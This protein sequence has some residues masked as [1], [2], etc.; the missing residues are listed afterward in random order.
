VLRGQQVLFGAVASETTAHRVLKSVD[1][2]AREALRAA[3][4]V[5]LARA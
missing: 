1:A 3:R 4:T 5:A 2:E